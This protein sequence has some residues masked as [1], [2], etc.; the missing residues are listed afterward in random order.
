MAR[1]PLP[2]GTYGEIRCYELPS[3]KFRAIAN[4]RDYD[5]VTRPVERVGKTETKARDRLREALRDRGRV[6]AA[7]EIT[8][9]TKV[10]ALA[11]VWF[12]EIAE[13][14]AE[15]KKSP[16]TGR[17]YR[18]RLDN[19]II[20]AIG[21]LRLREVT[22]SRADKL[23]KTVKDKHGNAVAKMTRTVLSGVLGLA[24]RHDVFDHNPVRDV[25]RIESTDKPARALELDQARELR[26]KIAG[27]KVAVS[28]DLPDFT[29][30][31]AATGLRIGETAA[32]VW[33]AVDLDAATVEVRGTVVRIK[34]VGL[35]IKPKP[36]SKSGYRKV[37]LPTWAV[38]VL[39]ARRSENAQPGDPVFTAP[40]GGLRDPSNTNADLKEAFAKA[41]YS[42]VTSHVYRKTVAS[43]M[44]D[45]GLSARAA[46][47][48]LGHAKVSMTQDKYFKR[49]VSR[50]GAAAIL[51]AIA[52]TE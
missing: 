4:Y 7:S 9:D 12:A 10:S 31:M 11:E 26:A 14:V 15:G 24:T 37:E 19:Q 30:M 18:D 33:D 13:E 6:D 47:D 17:Q 38:A 44:D 8:P 49:K 42:W 50:T 43:M 46:A 41:G 20:P 51:E 5:G 27:D 25:R 16:D 45:A 21:G 29:D 39:R 28:R 3:G 40:R 36:K 23:I 22:V 34:G 32:I 2:V 52:A 48:Q 35:V 1:P